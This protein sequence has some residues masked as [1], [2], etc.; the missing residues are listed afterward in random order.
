MVLTKC[1]ITKSLAQS[2]AI[3]ILINLATFTLTFSAPN[4]RIDLNLSHNCFQ[5]F[6]NYLK[7]YVKYCRYIFVCENFVMTF[8]LFNYQ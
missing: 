5:L 1:R 8:V 3:G 6:T 4:Y 7:I 2:L